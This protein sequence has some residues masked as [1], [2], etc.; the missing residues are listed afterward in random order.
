MSWT[1][2]GRVGS[3]GWREPRVGFGDRLQLSVGWSGDL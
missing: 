3:G 2:E 1:E